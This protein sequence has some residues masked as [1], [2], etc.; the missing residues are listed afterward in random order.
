MKSLVPLALA[1]FASCA[2]NDAPPTS[3]ATTALSTNGGASVGT[4]VNY[5]VDWS[6]K[7]TSEDLW[8]TNA[9]ITSTQV[10][11]RKGQDRA[12]GT[13]TFIAVVVWNHTTV[14][15]IYWVNRGTDG[16]NFHT[17]L[18]NTIGA[19]CNNAPDHGGGGDGVPVGGTPPIPRPNVSYFTVDATFLQNAKDAALALDNATGPQSAFVTYVTQ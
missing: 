2:V 14:G 17:L 15:H 1:L 13:H 5:S 12:D 9:G 7:F 8:P 6:D 10:L 3:T 4:D 18:D 16:S 11:I 19:R